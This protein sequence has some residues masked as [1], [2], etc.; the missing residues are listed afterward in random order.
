MKVDIAYWDGSYDNTNQKISFTN[1]ETALDFI[2]K[3][4]NAGGN[5]RIEKI[6]VSKDPI[7]EV[8]VESL[9]R[10]VRGY[11]HPNYVNDMTGNPVDHFVHELDNHGGVFL[12]FGDVIAK[13][14]NDS[15]STNFEGE[16]VYLILLVP[17]VNRLFRVDGTYVRVN[18]GFSYKIDWN[19][20][21]D[22]REVAPKQVT[23]YDAV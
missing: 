1:V 7:P 11:Y 2:V 21:N 22:V 13:E 9:Q 19:N 10:F 4:Q 3:T 8:S 12:P 5:S 17:S 15:S 6:S 20:F 23:V 16:N 14:W 18:D